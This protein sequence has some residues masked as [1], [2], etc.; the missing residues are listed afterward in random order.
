MRTRSG[1]PWHGRRTVAL[2]AAVAFAASL[3]ASPVAPA[4]Q[5][6]AAPAPTPISAAPG[7]LA[8]LKA[9]EANIAAQ[10]AAGKPN[11][12][13]IDLRDLQSFDIESLWNQ[14]ID[15]TGTS[16]AVIEGWDLPSI[17]TTLNTLDAKIGLPDTTVTTVYPSGPLPAVCPAGMQALGNYGSC[18]AWGG[19]LTLDVEAVHLFAPYAKI[20]ISATPADSEIADDRSSQV[21]PPE[22]MKALEYLSAHKLADVISISDGSNEGDYSNGAAEIHAQDP[23][24]LAAAAAGIP[25]VN[26]TGDCGAAQNLAT[27][28]G[29]CNDTTTTRA[30]ATWDDS[31]YVTAVGGVTPAHTFTGPNGQDAFSVWNIGQVEAEGAGFSQIYA[32]PDYQN[33]VASI[34]G[35][36]MRSLPDITMDARDGTSQSAPQFAAVLALATQVHGG[37]L[38]AINEMLY[39]DLGQDPAANGLVDVTTGNNTAYG[40]TGFS[41]AAGYDVATGWGTID[42]A[43]FV[44]ALASAAKSAPDRNTLTLQAAL[45]LTKLSL[46]A[47]A[48][49]VVDA[50][51][52]PTTITAHG[53]LPNHP[54]T[55]ADGQRVLATVTAN[56]A[57]EVTYSLTPQAAGLSPGLHAII[58]TGLL[59]TQPTLLIVY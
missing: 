5:A 29:F 13:D 45:E 39:N 2:A 33:R 27:A 53:F 17:Q 35:S 46:T 55:I 16:V 47:N 26:A 41:A 34:T 58:L 52:H 18:S 6:I 25:V 24:E 44:P 14:G 30:V 56:S 37:H 32:R 20:V 59:I 38:G 1:D 57:G 51:S 43:R 50:R 28:T 48:N 8:A 10:I 31:P 9:A 11:W 4:A 22:M 21:A 15:G 49:P 36:S 23:G 42:A 7:R 19:E 12:G 40:V 54:V 3:I